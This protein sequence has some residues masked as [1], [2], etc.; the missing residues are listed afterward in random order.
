MEKDKFAL[1][2][3]FITGT[4]EGVDNYLNLANLV[5]VLL[6][7]Q[8]SFAGA[9]NRGLKL[10]FVFKNSDVL[11]LVHAQIVYHHWQRP[12]GLSSVRHRSP[13]SKRKNEHEN[14][15]LNIGKSTNRS[16]SDAAMVESSCIADVSLE[17]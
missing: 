5:F 13:W 9:V 8:I 17:I 15:Q 6:K 1:T 4:E 2:A 14:R 7:K 10:D 3:R 16:T 12:S 11:F